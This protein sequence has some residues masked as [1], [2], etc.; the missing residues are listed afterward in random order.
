[1]ARIFGKAA[2]KAPEEEIEASQDQSQAE[3]PKEKKE[4]KVTIIE[5]EVNLSLINEK[6]NYLIEIISKLK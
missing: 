1:M 5:R 6:L 4:E 2:Q 3:K